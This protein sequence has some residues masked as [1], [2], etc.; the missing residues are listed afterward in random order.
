MMQAGPWCTPDIHAG[1]LAQ[2]DDQNSRP[3][4]KK[5]DDQRAIRVSCVHT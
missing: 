2:A 3:L 4:H 5:A 1:N